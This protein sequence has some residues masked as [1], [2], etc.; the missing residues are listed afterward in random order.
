LIFACARVNGRWD[1]SHKEKEMRGRWMYVCY[2][3]DQPYRSDDY[4][5]CKNNLVTK[6]SLPSRS[7]VSHL[8]SSCTDLWMTWWLVQ[9]SIKYRWQ[10]TV[11]PLKNES[12]NS[13]QTNINRSEAIH[14]WPLR[15]SSGDINR[16]NVLLVCPV[17]WNI[18]LLEA[19][20]GEEVDVTPHVKTSCISIN[21]IKTAEGGVKRSY[22]SDGCNLS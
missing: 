18:G 2:A 21:L 8:K 10:N 7:L 15:D 14:Q 20:D 12:W 5:V 16:R 3:L 13:S 11:A 17:S 6:A 19:G 1:R 22:F 4:V 9:Q